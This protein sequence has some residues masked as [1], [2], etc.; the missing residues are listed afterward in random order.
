MMM[1]MM[2]I[3]ALLRPC[4]VWPVHL[5]SAFLPFVPRLYAQRYVSGNLTLFASVPLLT[6]RQ[7]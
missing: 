6:F 5:P 7:D 4:S 1:M 3:L 2:M